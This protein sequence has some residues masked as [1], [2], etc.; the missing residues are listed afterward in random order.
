MGV[1]LKNVIGL[2]LF[3]T[4]KKN[5]L[6]Q[7]KTHLAQIKNLVEKS[8]SQLV[9]EA[10]IFFGCLCYSGQLSWHSCKN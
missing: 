10:T 6:T 8:P 3:Y 7:R 9:V 2:I 5:L 4:L 1:Y